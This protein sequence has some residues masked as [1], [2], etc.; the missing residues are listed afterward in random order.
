MAG[1]LGRSKHTASPCATHNAAVDIRQGPI[2]PRQRL[3]RDKLISGPSDQAHPQ[4][5]DGGGEHRMHWGGHRTRAWAGHQRLGREAAVEIDSRHH[6]SALPPT[7]TLCSSLLSMPL[8]LSRIID[9]LNLWHAP[10]SSSPP[11]PT[12]AQQSGAKGQG[13]GGQ[14]FYPAAHC[15]ISQN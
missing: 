15:G 2:L 5:I 14:A 12:H 3:H 10:E 13:G 11:A 9:A 4:S 6:V 7:P 1:D 8:S